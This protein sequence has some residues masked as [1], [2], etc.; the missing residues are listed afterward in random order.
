ML[1]PK[2]ASYLKDHH[3]QY[4]TIPHANAITASEIAQISHISGK[5]LAKSVAVKVD[6]KVSLVALPANRRLNIRTF[7]KAANANN[8]E[9]M[10]EYE[11]QDRFDDCEV[12][13]MPP[14][15]ELYNV[16]IY[17]A[18]SLAK[19]NWIAFNAGNHHELLKMNSLDYIN[20]EH[21]KILKD[22]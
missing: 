14:L 6:G 5:R 11:F 4:E 7:R 10:R 1:S 9:V 2:I 16:D 21:P 13:A 8:V 15:G 18:G 17:I 22:L 12:G 3:V 20:L 19:Q